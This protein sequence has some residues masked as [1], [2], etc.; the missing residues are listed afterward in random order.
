MNL[1]VAGP[2]TGR[3]E[4]NR[5]EFERVRAMLLAVGHDAR[6]PH[7]FGEDATRFPDKDLAW[8]PVAGAPWRNWMWY[9][10]H[11]LSSWQPDGVVLLDDWRASRGASLEHDMF[12]GLGLRRFTNRAV[13]FFE[14]G[15]VSPARSWM[16]V[17][18]ANVPGGAELWPSRDTPGDDPFGGS[19][20]RRE[21]QP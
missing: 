5:P 2:I 7:E 8:R 15:G 19:A 13:G 17:E 12:Q 4:K 6:I 16:F 3:Q 11:Y 9:C 18:G 1:Y 21:A 14:V 20:E 10:F